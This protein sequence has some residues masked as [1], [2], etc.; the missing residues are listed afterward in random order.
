MPKKILLIV[1]Q[2]CP[3]G[4]IGTRRWSKFAKYLSRKDMEV[5]VLCAR[6]PYRDTINWCHEVENNPK[7]IIH[8]IAPMY[9]TYLL[10]PQRN[11]WIKLFDRIF[12][13]TVFYL[14]ASQYWGISMLPK[15]KEIITEQGITTVIASGG[16]FMALYH[17]ARLKLQLPQLRLILDFRDPWSTWLPN[18]NFTERRRKKKAEQL[19]KY[20]IPK[21]DKT[22]FTTHQLLNQYAQIFPQEAQKFE[23]LYNGF[24]EDDFVDLKMDQTK[25]LQIVYAGSLI[26]ER[27]NAVVAI[28]KALA[29]M[30]D[31][32]LRKHLK[33][34][35]YGFHYQVPS[36]DSPELSNQYQHYVQYHGVIS[37]KEVF[38]VLL[39]NDI[40][41]SINAPGHEHLIGA[42]T[43]DYMGLERKIFLISKP[44]EL[45]E[46]LEEKGQYVADYDEPSIIESLLK[47]KADF[48][49]PDNFQAKSNY[50]E[51]NYHTLTNQLVRLLVDATRS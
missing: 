4:Q 24:D 29:K 40:C 30:E 8:R 51:F 35:L 14:D 43:F 1:Y 41:L 3:K 16:P 47:M 15:A 2:F 6:Y 27:V 12:S 22:L 38:Q 13:K 9:F 11:F 19:E 28:V 18:F 50:E 7:I 37:Q 45:S 21:A 23:V 34:H 26:K 25:P 20:T 49:K 31:A 42:K 46:I 48:L 10:K 5:H 39:Q 33:I 44:G 17:A 32:I 36:F